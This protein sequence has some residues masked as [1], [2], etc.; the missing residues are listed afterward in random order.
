MSKTVTQRETLGGAD[1][2]G[3]VMRV[4]GCGNAWA[5]DDSAGLEIVRRLRVRGSCECELLE[6]PHAGVELMEVL[7]DVERVL[8]I[9]AVSSGAPAGTLHLV[10]L[11]SVS[12]VPRT[13]SSI[14]SH[15]W[16]LAETLRLMA[17]LRHRIPRLALLGVEIEAA[18]PGT[19]RSAAVES[20]IQAV[21]ERF[22]AFEEFL[23]LEGQWDWATPR[24][25]MPGDALCGLAKGEVPTGKGGF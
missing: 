12:I 4:V 20:A 10:P 25:F 16:G 15:G 11:P 1:G 22:A 21:L 13:I 5:G 6:R 9:D 18:L 23:A 24:R 3:V 19:P 14:S 7:R 2:R 17:A 8:F